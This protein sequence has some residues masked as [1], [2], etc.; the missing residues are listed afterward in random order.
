MN[1][2]NN[3]YASS[4]RLKKRPTWLPSRILTKA[5]TPRHQRWQSKHLNRKINTKIT[6]ARHL[7]LHPFYG[8]TIYCFNRGRSP[9]GKSRSF[10]P[11]GA[12]LTTTSPKRSSAHKILWK[13]L[14][15][16]FAA[17]IM[18]SRINLRPKLWSY[19]LENIKYCRSY[20]RLKGHLRWDALI[21]EMK[22][23]V[24][25]SRGHH[26]ILTTIKAYNPDQLR[27]MQL[28]IPKTL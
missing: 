28:R 27:V 12:S 6:G 15:W 9:L 13:R 18:S 22:S 23:C 11:W 5:N 4:Q 3:C 25:S 21:V 26:F 7:L 2:W 17:S 8:R 16:P 10:L 24:S 14:T 1:S 19:F 20:G